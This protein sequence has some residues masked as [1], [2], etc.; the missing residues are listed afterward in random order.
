VRFAEGFA[1]KPHFHK[2]HNETTYIIRGTG[3]ILINNTWIDVKSGNIHFNPMGKVHATRNTGNE[4]LVFIAIFT[5]AM[6]ER[7]MIFVE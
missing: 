3:Q 5:P 2:S 7:D 6:K 4:Q 1:A